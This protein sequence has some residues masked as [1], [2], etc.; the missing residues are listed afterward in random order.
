MEAGPRQHS[1]HYLVRRKARY[2]PRHRSVLMYWQ[3]YLMCFHSHHLCSGCPPWPPS[4]PPHFLHLP[5]PP[6]GLPS[7]SSS[8]LVSMHFPGIRLHL[9]P[10]LG[11]L[12]LRLGGGGVMAVATSSFSLPSLDFA[13]SPGVWPESSLGGCALDLLSM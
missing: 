1:G 3:H 5:A 9:L 7:P 2:C 11:L 4:P 6:S 12:M 13:A 10:P 8:Q